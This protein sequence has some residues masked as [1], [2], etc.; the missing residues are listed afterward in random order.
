MPTTGQQKQTAKKTLNSD[1]AKAFL[2]DFLVVVKLHVGHH[3]LH[4][5]SANLAIELD[6]LQV[7]ANELRSGLGAAHA[8]PEAGYF[9][10]CYLGRE[11]EGLS[12]LGGG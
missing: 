4:S 12:G 5:L 3:L 8:S 2:G 1:S 6:L 11:L 9:S 10:A 7:L